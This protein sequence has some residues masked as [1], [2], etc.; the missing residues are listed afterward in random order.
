MVKAEHCAGKFLWLKCV[1]LKK[2]N[3]NL[4]CMDVNDVN[5]YMCIIYFL[6]SGNVN[7]MQHRCLC[8]VSNEQMIPCSI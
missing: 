8:C 3:Y 1:K 4:W 6:F 2:K 7:V 5:I